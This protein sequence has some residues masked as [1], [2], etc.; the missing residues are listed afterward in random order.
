LSSV[1]KRLKIVYSYKWPVLNL[2]TREG[3]KAELTWVL[4]VG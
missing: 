1:H 2:P 4:A 3:W